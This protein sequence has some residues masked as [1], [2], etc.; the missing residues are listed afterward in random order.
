MIPS[1]ATCILKP[2]PHNLIVRLTP[3]IG[4]IIGDIH[5]VAFDNVISWMM[6]LLNGQNLESS[7]AAWSYS[8]PAVLICFP[9]NETATNEVLYIAYKIALKY[10]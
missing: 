3:F 6:Q 10:E 2:L 4:L 7:L 5:T 1:L 8:L 9:M